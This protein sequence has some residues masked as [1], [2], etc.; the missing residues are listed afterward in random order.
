VRPLIV[1][2]EVAGDLDVGGR[3]EWLETNGLGSFAMGTIAGPATRRY[4][5]L[6]CA[7][8]RPPSGRMV[9]VNRC[10]EELRADGVGYALSANHYPGTVWPDGHVRLVEFRLDPWPTWIYRCGGLQVERTL[11][12]PHRRQSTVMSWRLL[13]AGR[14]RLYVKPLISG[15]DYHALH[16]ENPAL[17]REAQIGEGLVEIHPYDGVPPLFVHHNG[18]FHARPD[19]YRNFRYPVEEERGLDFEEDLFQP[20][21]VAFDLTEGTAA[22]VVFTL[23]G[24]IVPEVDAWRESER[25]RRARLVEGAA[26]D[27]DARLRTAADQF[28][29]ARA[30]HQTII[31]GYPWFTDWGRDTFI[32]LPGLAL[33]TGRHAIA[34]ELLFAFAPHVRDGLVPNRFPD[35]GEEPEYNTVDA[36]L[37]YALAACRYVKASGD[38]GAFAELK[39]ALHQ[40]IDRY[41]DGTRHNIGIDDD[42]LIHA[43]EPGLQLTWMD[44]KVGDWVVTPRIGKPVEIQALWIAA[45]ESIAELAQGD[46]PTWARELA[47]RA[48]WARS[49]FA[50]LFWDDALGWMY[51]CVDG[52]SRDG[53]LRP[54]QLY[55]LGLAAPLV[56]A[57]KAERALAA[58][59]RELLTPFGLRTRARGDGYLGRYG[60]D[61]RERD[62]AYHQGTVWPFLIGAYAD[63]CL[64]VRGALPPNLLD[65]LRKHLYGDG[66]GTIAEIFDGDSPHRP[67]GCPAQAWSVAETLRVHVMMSAR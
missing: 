5:A 9:L 13:G 2:G 22:V 64:R 62:G 48:A 37:W 8:T 27:F 29:V 43:G 36:P 6:L 12:M 33:A 3:R 56:D 42:G 45:L 50:S 20:G 18:V 23:E 40:I 51:D 4:H 35:A 14:A 66:V 52:R 21:E 63:A 31:A 54:N 1:P 32:S 7:A 25:D 10:E 28:V 16:H 30:Q 65:G 57:E 46:D 60:G 38:R 17:R 26:D 53:T 61:Q 24:R 44:A 67:A 49:S 15:R 58:V 19:W 41:L 34:R 59:E 11:F 47:E 55:A 39:P